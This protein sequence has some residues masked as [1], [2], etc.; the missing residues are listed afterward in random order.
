MHLR[1]WDDLNPTQSHRPNPVMATRHEVWVVT[2]PSTAVGHRPGH[3][4]SKRRL[5]PALRRWELDFD[6]MTRRTPY[7]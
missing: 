5:L 7:R 6:G 3:G 1:V 2:D 4:C